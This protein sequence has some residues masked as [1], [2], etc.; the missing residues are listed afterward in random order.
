MERNVPSKHSFENSGAHVQQN[1]REGNNI[2]EIN[3]DTF[4]EVKGAQSG[5]FELFLSYF[6][7]KIKFN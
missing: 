2:R 3:I 1:D 4:M 5:Y 6:T 7:Y